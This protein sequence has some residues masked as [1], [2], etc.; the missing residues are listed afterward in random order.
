MGEVQFV[1]QAP[2]AMPMTQHT[3]VFSV[4]DTVEAYIKISPDHRTLED[5]VVTLTREQAL[6]LAQQLTAAVGNCPIGKK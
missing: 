2:Y 3:K 4:G 5:V 1:G 6:L